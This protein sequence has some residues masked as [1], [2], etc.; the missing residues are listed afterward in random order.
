VLATYQLGVAGAVEV[1]VAQ[2]FLAEDGN[3]GGVVEL[4]APVRGDRVFPDAA[5][6]R[7]SDE[8]RPARRPAAGAT[9]TLPPAVT[10]S[11]E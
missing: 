9:A 7:E 1:G 2:V 3:H 6:N 10:D 4:A 11:V 5:P 8:P